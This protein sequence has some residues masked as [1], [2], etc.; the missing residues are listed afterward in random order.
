[1]QGFE[2]IVEQRIVEAARRGDFDDL[3]GAGQPLELDDDRL[4][5]EELRIA[6]RI[7]RNAG[8]VPPEVQILK[9]VAEL[10]R[11]VHASE[12]MQRSV[13][14]KKLRL[15]TMQMSASRSGNLQLEAAYYERMAERLSCA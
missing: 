7:L 10:E 15:L 9:D 1:M 6:Y 2:A 4:I 11:L 3:P 13:A 12:G 14:L 5:P 8:Y